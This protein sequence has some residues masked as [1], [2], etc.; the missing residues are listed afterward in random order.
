MTVSSSSF[1]KEC[2]NVWHRSQYP[3]STIPPE[4]ITFYDQFT[5]ET[6]ENLLNPKKIENTVSNISPEKIISF[7][8]LYEPGPEG[9]LLKS[10]GQ[11]RSNGSKISMSDKPQGAKKKLNFNVSAVGNQ[12]GTQKHSQQKIKKMEK[13]I[14]NMPE[15]FS[16][17]PDALNDSDY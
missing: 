1:R 14:A 3:A 5:K 4:E 10:D 9:F 6:K 13:A 12:G 11:K 17:N 7:Y 15:N 2:W 16:L 8:D